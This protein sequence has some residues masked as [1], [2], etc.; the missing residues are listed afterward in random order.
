MKP[1]ERPTINDQIFK[2][3]IFKYKIVIQNLFKLFRYINLTIVKLYFKVENIM[4]LITYEGLKL[5]NNQRKS[6]IKEFNEAA[7]RFINNIP[8]Q[9]YYVFIRD[10]QD[11]NIGVG[12]VFLKDYKAELEG[13]NNHEK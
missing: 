2:N 12:G 10:H 6:L 5:N 13:Y 7:C 1:P 4:P 11:E 9:A 3:C 8:K